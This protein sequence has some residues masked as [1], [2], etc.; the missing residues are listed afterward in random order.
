MRIKI[1][2]SFQCA[3]SGIKHA[4]KEQTIKILFVIAFLAVFLS[5]YFNLCFIEKSIIFLSITIVLGIELINSQVERTLNIVRP[6]ICE[7]VRKIKDISAG[8]VL[9]ASLGA[10]I[11]GFLIF[12]PYFIDFL[13]C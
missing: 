3:F 5:F 4:L 1:F 8:A 10:A 7:E 2:K 6:E 9:I 13:N 12:S 11:V